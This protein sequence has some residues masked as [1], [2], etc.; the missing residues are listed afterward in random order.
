MHCELKK[1]Y[2]T[3]RMMIEYPTRQWKHST[4]NDLIKRIDETERSPANLLGADW[5]RRLRCRTFRKQLSLVV[6]TDRGHFEHCF[7]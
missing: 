2:E 6:A 7:D 3:L 5:P 1:R 4:L